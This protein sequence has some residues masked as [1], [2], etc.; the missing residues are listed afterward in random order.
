MEVQ[1]AKLRFSAPKIL[2]RLTVSSA[3]VSRGLK[4]RPS[5]QERFAGWLGGLVFPTL[6]HLLLIA[7]FL[8]ASGM[9]MLI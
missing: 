4:R 8:F 1:I 2:Q 3:K 6:G 9:P 7:S 5:P